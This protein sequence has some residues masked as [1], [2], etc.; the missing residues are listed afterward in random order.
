MI[1]N[2]NGLIAL[3]MLVMGSGFLA[4]N[5]SAQ[6]KEGT[7]TKRQNYG[8]EKMME[9]KA[10]ILNID[11]SLLM[12]KIKNGATLQDILSEKGLTME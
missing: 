8:F 7:M 12:E 2:R 9:A 5:A 1:K 10:K 3:M 6:V 11:K 4:S